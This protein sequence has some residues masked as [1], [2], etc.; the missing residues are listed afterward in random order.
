M[1]SRSFTLTLTLLAE[2][3]PRQPQLL[4]FQPLIL[5]LSLRIIRMNHSR[6]VRIGGGMM[7]MLIKA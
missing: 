7:E 4:S 3:R 6:M 1:D 5:R 2:K